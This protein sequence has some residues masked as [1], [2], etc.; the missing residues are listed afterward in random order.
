MSSD[1]AFPVPSSYET[2]KLKEEIGKWCDGYGFLGWI[3][4]HKDKLSLSQLALNPNP[5]V[6]PVIEK[7]LQLVSP[8]PDFWVNLSGNPNA[9]PIL[10]KNLHNLTSECWKGYPKI[11]TQFL[12]WK[13]IRIKLIGR[14][15]H[16]IQVYLNRFSLVRIINYK[17]GSI[18]FF[19]SLI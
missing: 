14:P 7:Q 16:K 11:Q 8:I 13:T 4:A 3:E 12:F 17:K 9:I 1:I 5:N 10:E 6:I 18:P 15:S 19:S 2:H